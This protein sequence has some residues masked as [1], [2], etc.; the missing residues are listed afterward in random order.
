M[1]LDMYLYVKM[2]QSVGRNEE[3][4]G[5]YPKEVE[6]LAK[7]VQTSYYSKTTMYE[8]GYWRKA[9]AIHHWIVLNCND[10]IDD[11]SSIW[12]SIEKAEELL[13]IVKQV[14]EN[15]NLASELLPTQEGFFF[16]STEYDDW[17]WEDLEYTE[18]LLENVIK[19]CKETYAEIYYEA[20]W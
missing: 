7:K 11:C 18:N 8:I 20:S 2:Y 10:E 3:T 15:H 9:N 5:F 6:E 17:Y 1:G 14:R 19:F 16:G 12:V 13:N 4:V